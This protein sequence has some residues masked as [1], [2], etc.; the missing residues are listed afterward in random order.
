[1]AV[2]QAFTTFKG[3]D[4]KFLQADAQVDISRGNDALLTQ[5]FKIE[6]GSLFEVEDYSF[7]VMQTLNIGSQST[8][9]G[10]GKVTFNPFSITR[11]IDKA[12]PKLFEMCCSGAA[13]ANV[14]LLLRKG[15]GTA[16]G[17]L[18]IARFDFKLV[19]VKTIAWKQGT[20][21]PTETVGFEYGG[22]QVRY[23]AQN[24]DGSLTNPIVAGWNRVRN[25]TDTTDAPIR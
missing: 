3:Y 2:T 12:S 10:A 22:L 6:P 5:P 24:P 9:A 19:A 20:E 13:F 18:T 16:G 1:M 15:S 23:V 14:A 21:V 11:K 4:G 7:D 25:A 17:A 8:G